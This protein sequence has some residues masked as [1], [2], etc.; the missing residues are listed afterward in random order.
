MSLGVKIVGKKKVRYDVDGK[1]HTAHPDEIP[2]GH[3]MRMSE[4]DHA[5][6]QNARAG[7]AAKK[8][9]KDPAAKGRASLKGWAARRASFGGGKSEKKSEGGGGGGDERDRDDLGRF[10]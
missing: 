2:Y 5:E 4:E 6:L 1:T 9:V 3:R 10:A 8:E 7:V